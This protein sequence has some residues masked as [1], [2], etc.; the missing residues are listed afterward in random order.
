MMQKNELRALMAEQL[1]E[2]RDDAVTMLIMADQLAH[3]LREKLYDAMS[4]LE[5][6]LA[7]SKQANKE[8]A[9]FLASIKETQRVPGL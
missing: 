3:E 4:V 5:A 1:R 7:A 9:D 2:R 8:L 6:A